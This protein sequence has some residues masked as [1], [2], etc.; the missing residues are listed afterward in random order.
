MVADAVLISPSLLSADFAR[1]REEVALVEAAGAHLL[2][3]DVMDGHFVPN[4]TLGP[5]IV[6]AIHRVATVP[7]DVHLMIDRP[8]H[9]AEEFV[10]AGAGRLTYH[11]ESQEGGPET[12]D[13]IREL[14]AMPSVSIR[15]DTP[16]D[17]IR[18]HLPHVDMV[19]IMSVM[20][21]FAGQKF[22][23]EV[24]AKTRALRQEL[25]YTGDIEMDGGIDAD[26]IGACA[27]A[28]ANVFVAG[29]AIYGAADPDAALKTLLARAQAARYGGR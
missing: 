11:V 1:L 29:S 17:A 23:P 20:P 13:R 2:H 9:Y 8:A 21:G 24:L 6:K 27:E 28:G 25:G 22:M 18:D 10:A 15:P 4:L 19:L 7:L 12:A 26:T 16:L 5:F 3:V 14:G